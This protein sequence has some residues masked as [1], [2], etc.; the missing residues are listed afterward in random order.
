[1]SGSTTLTGRGRRAHGDANGTR[2]TDCAEGP[3]SVRLG[4]RGIE[5]GGTVLPSGC[6]AASWC[7]EVATMQGDLRRNASVPGTRP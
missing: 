7:P 3:A 6:R 5:R 4:E 1:M 2:A